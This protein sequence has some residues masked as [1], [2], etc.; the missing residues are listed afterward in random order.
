M[1]ELLC[2]R[3]GAFETNSSS[4]HSLVVDADSN[5]VPQSDIDRMI[6]DGV[7]NIDSGEFGWERETFSYPLDKLSYLYTDAMLRESDDVDPNDCDNAK[8]ETIREAVEEYTGAKV[9]FKKEAVSSWGYPFGYIDHESVGLA[10][11]VTNAGKEAVID[12]VFRTGS[13]FETDNDNY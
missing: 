2:Q 12:F 4:S 13:Y 3:K 9:N 6:V 8:L 7:I 11:D 5:L 1:Y 10:A